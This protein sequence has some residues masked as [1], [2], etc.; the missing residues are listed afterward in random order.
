VSLNVFLIRLKS[1]FEL[2]FVVFYCVEFVRSQK[3]KRVLYD[4]D[5]H[6]RCC[7]MHYKTNMCSMTSTCIDTAAACNTGEDAPPAPGD[8][9]LGLGSSGVHSNGYSLVRRVVRDRQLDYASPGTNGVAL[10]FQMLNNE[11]R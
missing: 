9:L 7:C 8:V 6:E 2:F 5:V 3:N 10:V 4:I 1:F 11:Q